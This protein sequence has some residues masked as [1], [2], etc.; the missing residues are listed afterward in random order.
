MCHSRCG[1]SFPVCRGGG[2]AGT[3]VLCSA[4]DMPGRLVTCGVARHLQPGAAQPHTD[5][6]CRHC[7]S[8][9]FILPAGPAER[10][11][12]SCPTRQPRAR[13]RGHGGSR[14]LG[15]HGEEQRQRRCQG[16][17]RVPGSAGA[18]GVPVAGSAR[19]LQLLE[20]DGGLLGS[21]ALQAA[22]HLPWGQ[23]GAGCEEPV[24][25]E[26]P[27]FPV[28]PHTIPC[29]SWCPMCPC[30]SPCPHKF[31]SATH[32]DVPPMSAAPSVPVPEIG[33]AHV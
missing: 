1:Y 31:L 28:P 32:H 10:G 23:G 15:E 6:R 22:L 21:C 4:G 8:H 2:A 9:G 19:P 24:C 27:H 5:T 20:G 12:G 3:L 18:F 11:A 33:R 17:R 30:A 13:C 7:S 29:T 26:P 25:T 14:V 16:C